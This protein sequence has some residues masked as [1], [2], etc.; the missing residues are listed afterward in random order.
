LA[1]P[2]TARIS[3]LVG[4]VPYYG[5]VFP[6]Q[7]PHGVRGAVGEFGAGRNGGRTH[8]G[9]DIV[10]ACETPLVAV[11]NGRVLQAG[12]DLV[13]YGNYLLIHGEGE[14]RSYFYAHLPRPS[15]FHKGDRVWEGERVGAVG[16]T[17]NAITIG[18]H[19]HFEIHVHGVPVDPLPSLERWDRYS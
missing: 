18:C 5:H 12:Y 11:S 10:A 19:L 15:P 17:G 1:A 16:K 9:F 13:L 14:Q 6:V 8:E 3:S 2:A 7:G 4:G